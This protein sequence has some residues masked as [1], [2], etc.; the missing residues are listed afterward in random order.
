MDATA[1]AVGNELRRN[2]SL[3]DGEVIRLLRRGREYWRISN[4]L[5]VNQQIGLTTVNELDALAYLLRVCGLIPPRF[6]NAGFEHD[7]PMHAK[8]VL[9]R[10]N[11]IEQL[12]A[13]LVE[14]MTHKVIG[15]RMREEM[16]ANLEHFHAISDRDRK[17]ENVFQCSAVDDDREFLLQLVTDRLVHVVNDRRFLIVGGID[18]NDLSRAEAAQEIFG[19]AVLAHRADIALGSPDSVVLEKRL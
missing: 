14:A 12:G 18:G 2:P 6:S 15:H 11:T 1:Q 19:I 3:P 10:E 4:P 9:R 16:T 17:I 13:E 8:P 5:G 7:S